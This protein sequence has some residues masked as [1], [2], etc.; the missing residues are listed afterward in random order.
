M[1]TNTKNARGL[2]LDAIATTL[3]KR[4]G[5]KYVVT[6]R[7]EYGWPTFWAHQADRKDGAALFNIALSGGLSLEEMDAVG[8]AL[9]DAAQELQCQVSSHLT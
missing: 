1:D 8:K 9:I 3:E 7:I 5:E 6:A 2:A 4:L